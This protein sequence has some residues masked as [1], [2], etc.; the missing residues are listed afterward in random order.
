MNIHEG[1]LI[2]CWT[3]IKQAPVS[4]Q[5]I[6]HLKAKCGCLEQVLAWYYMSIKTWSI[7]GF[8]S[9]VENSVPNP[10]W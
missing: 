2:F 3:C 10:K 6:L 8:E 4:K 1:K 5:E 9:Y 7:I